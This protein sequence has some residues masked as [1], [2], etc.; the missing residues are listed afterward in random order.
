MPKLVASLSDHRFPV[1]TVSFDN[2]PTDKADR[3]IPIQEYHLLPQGVEN[4]RTFPFSGRRLRV[5]AAVSLPQ[6]QRRD[7]NAKQLLLFGGE[8]LR[9]FHSD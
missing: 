2:R 1:E 5:G 4:G 8:F 3:V 6:R 7:E 9:A